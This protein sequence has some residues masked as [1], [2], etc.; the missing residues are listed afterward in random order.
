MDTINGRTEYNRPSIPVSGTYPDDETR[1]IL[2]RKLLYLK[3][4]ETFRR[5]TLVRTTQPILQGV[6]V[7]CHADVG[8]RHVSRAL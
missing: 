3:S 8:Q 7:V 2:S 6:A 1:V 4:A 5:R